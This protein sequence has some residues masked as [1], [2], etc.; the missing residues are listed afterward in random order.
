MSMTKKDYELVSDIF[1]NSMETIDNSVDSET[2]RLD[3]WDAVKDT[4]KYAAF[5]FEKD[6]PKFKREQFL[7]D[8]G[9]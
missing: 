9:L 6:N 3:M 1:L 8:C 2:A 7:K 4:A 5:R